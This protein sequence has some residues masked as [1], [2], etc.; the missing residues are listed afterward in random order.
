MSENISSLEIACSTAPGT[1]G[2]R[3]RKYNCGFTF[4]SIHITYLSRISANRYR[5]FLWISWPSTNSNNNIFRRNHCLGKHQN[6]TSD[7]CGR[8][9]KH[10][11]N[12][13]LTSLPSLETA[14]IVC[15]S[16]KDPLELRYFT[17]LK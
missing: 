10:Q 16:C 6:M 14:L 5:Y 13:R 9:S 2:I 4:S 8:S 7:E 17:L 11:L 1:L 12:F 3:E 15:L